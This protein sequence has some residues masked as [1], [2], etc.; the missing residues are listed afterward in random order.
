MA[1]KKY[2][3]FVAH[4]HGRH[5]L[6][7]IDL[8]RLLKERR[9][10]EFEDNSVPAIRTIK[11]TDCKLEREISERIESSDVVLVFTAQPSGWIEWELETARNRGKRIIAIVPKSQRRQSLEVK[12]RAD[13]VVAWD[14]DEIV[15]CIRGKPRSVKSSAEFGLQGKGGSSSVDAESANDI[16]APETLP[17]S[18]LPG[19]VEPTTPVRIEEIITGPSEPSPPPSQE[20]ALGENA[21]KRRG[22]FALLFGR[23]GAASAGRKPGA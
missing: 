9:Y 18:V 20:I 19:R 15:A 3:I 21:L 11:C 1:G 7:W 2:Q 6:L 10:F 23:R 16:A 14:A 4:S 17:R 5:A 13:H 8:M 22:L 12:R